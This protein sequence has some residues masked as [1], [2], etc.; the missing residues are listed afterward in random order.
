MCWAAIHCWM[1]LLRLVWRGPSGLL[2]HPR[3]IRRGAVLLRLI[4]LRAIRLG[5]IRFL[6]IHRRPIWRSLIGRRLVCFWPCA[7]SCQWCGA[8]GLRQIANGGRGNRPHVM[9]GNNGLRVN[10]LRGFIVIDRR[11]LL[12]VCA[13]LMLHLDLRGHGLRVRFSQRR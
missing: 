9:V 8:R 4:R 12:A 3:L 2:S 5:A 1:I 13:G 6:P 10:H 7:L 11:K